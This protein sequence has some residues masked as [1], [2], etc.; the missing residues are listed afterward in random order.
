MSDFKVFI[1]AAFIEDWDKL[2][3]I[4]CMTHVLCRIGVL[5]FDISHEPKSIITLSHQV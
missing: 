3:V 1:R 2:D 5:K 4:T